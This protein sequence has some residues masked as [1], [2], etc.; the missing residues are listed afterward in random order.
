MSSQSHLNKHGVRAVGSSLTSWRTNTGVTV[1][2]R[3]P[4]VA[5]RLPGRAGS[6]GR[7]LPVLRGRLQAAFK[8]GVSAHRGR[9]GRSVRLTISN[10]KGR[11]RRLN[12]NRVHRRSSEWETPG[13]LQSAAHLLDVKVAHAVSPRYCFHFH[14]VLSDQL[15]EKLDWRS[16]SVG[17]P[18]DDSQLSEV[19]PSVTG[20]SFTVFKV[21][22][23]Q[24]TRGI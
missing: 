2:C 6:H 15:A 1:G 5:L 16:G 24:L 19:R 11:Q 12:I 9:G 3:G 17:L 14:R 22:P 13:V 4:C 8:V 18:L 7:L 23:A 10:S 21:K 20:Q